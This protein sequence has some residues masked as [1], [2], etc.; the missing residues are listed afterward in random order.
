MFEKEGIE[1]DDGRV[2]S[3]QFVEYEHPIQTEMVDGHVSNG[4]KN[5]I[6]V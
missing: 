3:E 5:K 1:N 4:M 2:A 6:Q